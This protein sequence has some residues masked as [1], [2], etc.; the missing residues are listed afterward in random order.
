MVS[1]AVELLLSLEKKEE[2]K[3][4]FT[5]GGYVCLLLTAHLMEL[6]PRIYEVQA[7]RKPHIINLKHAS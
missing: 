2:K 6:L 1:I 3:K 7:F 5:P 4:K